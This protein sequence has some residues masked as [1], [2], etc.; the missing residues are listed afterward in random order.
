MATD[1]RP[2]PD[3]LGRLA[4]LAAA[5]RS[6]HLFQA[7]RLVE[8]AWPDRPR[9]GRSARPSQDPIRIGQQVELAFP[10]VTITGFDPG[11]A[12]A[13]GEGRPGRLV[14]LFFGLFG[15]MGPLPLHLT[16]YVRDRERNAHDRTLSAF[17]DAFHHRM[18]SL[19]YRAWASGE[20]APSFDRPGDDPFAEAVASF[21]GRRGAAYKDRDAM[22]D[23][24]KLYFAG[25]LVHGPKNEEGLLAIVSAF[26]RAP[27]TIE[28]FVGSWLELAPGDRGMLGRPLVL[29][30]SASL[31]SRVW[32]RQAK[33]RF[34][35]G[36]LPLRE[37][38]RLLPG[39]DSLRRLVAIV[40]NYCGDTLDW[41]VNLVLARGEAPPLSLGR[42]GNLGWTTWLGESARAREADDLHLHPAAARA[43]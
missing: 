39:G 26:F 25:R 29:G 41:D 13:E 31:G 10:P 40:R 11:T 4:A 5:P 17:A 7:L 32:S 37:Y 1:E 8:A 14:Q 38:R 20:P 27:C 9:L 42:Q 12:G 28:S 3:P 23:L 36:P 2:A 16:E 22:P 6:F 43:T 33:F 18:A 15:P 24:A 30:R 35:I 34:R 21:A 19:L